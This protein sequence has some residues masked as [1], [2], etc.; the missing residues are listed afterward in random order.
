MQKKVL[1][2][3]VTIAKNRICKR[4]CYQSVLPSI[5]TAYVKESITKACYHCQKQHMQKKV[6]A[7]SVTKSVLRGVQQ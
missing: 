1:P 2:K 3:R 7:K 5:K 6:L 4:K